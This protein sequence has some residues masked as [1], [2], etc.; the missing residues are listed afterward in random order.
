M[1]FLSPEE[2]DGVIAEPEGV[3]PHGKLA[4]PLEDDEPGV[5]EYAEVVHFPH[6]P[7][8]LAHHSGQS[9]GRL[10]QGSTPGGLDEPPLR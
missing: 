6:H 2:L 3:F 4:G 10:Y 5:P 1:Y 8:G 9:H 7:P